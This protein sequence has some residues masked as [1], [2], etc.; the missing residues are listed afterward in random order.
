MRWE[1]I[2]EPLRVQYRP[3]EDD[4]R[5]CRETGAQLAQKAAEKAGAG[6]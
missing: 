3:T 4:L 1:I 6:K 2:A 5:R